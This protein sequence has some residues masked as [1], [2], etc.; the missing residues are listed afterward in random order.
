MYRA[1]SIGSC[2]LLL[3]SSNY[4]D[5][6]QT[7]L[8]VI[9]GNNTVMGKVKM[10]RDWSHHWNEP[11]FRGRNGGVTVIRPA[12]RGDVAGTGDTVTPLAACPDTMV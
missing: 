1:G 6:L 5:W 8:K 10:I 11:M 12:R 7:P 2:N 4:P 9:T 3:T